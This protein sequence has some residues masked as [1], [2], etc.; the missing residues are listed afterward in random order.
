[1][2]YSQLD[3]LTLDLSFHLVP[4]VFQLKD[5]G[6][7]GF[8]EFL[9]DVRDRV[10]QRLVIVAQI[11]YLVVE[12]LFSHFLIENLIFTFFEFA[13]VVAQLF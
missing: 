6:V 5:L 10:E 4:A 1:M 3:A 7:Q 9:V 2:H 11:V 8:N 12:N 13:C